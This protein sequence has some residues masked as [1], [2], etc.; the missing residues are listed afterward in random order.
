MKLLGTLQHKSAFLLSLMLLS[1]V[2]ST[3]AFAAKLAIVIDDF[4]YRKKEDNQILQLPTA[5]SIAILPDSPHGKEVANKAH[6]QGR[7]ILIHMPMAP[8]SKQPLERDTLKPSMD[9]A[10]INR[11][12]QNAINNVPYAV[13]MNNHMGGS[14]CTGFSVCGFNK[15]LGATS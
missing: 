4:G 13:G 3:P 12:I 9:Q 7:E 15:L 8:I 6:A 14:G 10:E 2:V 5:V 1:L 11:I